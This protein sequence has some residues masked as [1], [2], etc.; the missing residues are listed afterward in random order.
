[1]G[2]RLH[3]SA[4]LFSEAVRALSRNKLRSAL[5]ALG[6][7]IGIAAV[8]CVVAIGRAGSDRLEEQLNALGENLV[9]IEAGSRNINGVRSGTHGMNTLTVEDAQAILREVPLIK[10]VS[11]HVDSKVSVAFGNRN[12]TTQYRGVAPEY[13]EIKRWQLAE[14][15]AFTDEQVEQAAN[16]CVIGQTVRD[17]LFGPEKAVGQDMRLN[18]QLCQ[19][20]G[21]LAPKGQSAM[22]WDQDDTLL[23]PFT[24]AQKKLRGKGFTWVDDIMCSAVSAQAVNPAIDE[25][26]MLLRQRHQIRADQEDDFN[27]RRPEEVI[28]AQLETKRTL[29]L[30]LISI[31]SISLLVGGIGIMNVMLVSVSQR[32]RE[33]GLRM[34]VGATE[35]F[36]QMQFL[37]EAVVLSVFGGVMG[38]FVGI[39]SSVVY[40][41][42][43]E[44]PMTIPTQALIIA[45]IFSIGVGIFFGLY[46]AMR[47]AR[48]DPIVALRYE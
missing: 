40:G 26:I 45:P 22:G 28:K 15:V 14:G 27:I 23:L 25:I 43:M 29:A 10:S 19:V 41:R 1:M 35:S 2:T 12:W 11:P 37:G 46:P 13:L 47:A 31:A 17:Q 8:V 39:G 7:T 42:L 3:F 36:V 48:L 21:V 38:I 4:T 30:F 32:T 20:I 34:A 33:I 44:W 5:A 16:V 6:I 24:T 9:Q 18:N